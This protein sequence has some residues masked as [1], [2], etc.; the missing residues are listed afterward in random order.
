[1][2]KKREK[3]TKAKINQKNLQNNYTQDFHTI[4]KDDYVVKNITADGNC[5]YRSLSF[6]YRQTEKDF[7]EFRKL[8]ISYIENNLDNYISFVAD[9]EINEPDFN[10]Y[11]E[12]I[13]INK[14]REYLL[15]YTD[16]AKQDKVWAC[17]LEISTASILFNIFDINFPSLLSTTSM[18]AYSGLV[19]IKFSNKNVQNIIYMDQIFNECTSLVSLDLSNLNFSSLQTMEKMFFNIFL[20]GSCIDHILI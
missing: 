16:K 18:F 8:I 10:N 1:M 3:K 4:N 9:E 7:D 12:D 11:S 14:K 2:N 5:F 15:D 13:K 17:Y 6:Y 19:S 20:E